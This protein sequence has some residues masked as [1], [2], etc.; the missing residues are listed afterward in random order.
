MP[1]FDSEKIRRML[2]K[3][4][5]HIWKEDLTE[6]DIDSHIVYLFGTE[7]DMNKK[8]L[9]EMLKRFRRTFNDERK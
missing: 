5:P 9:A 1:E 8:E 3:L 6:E 7:P 2:K 4:Y